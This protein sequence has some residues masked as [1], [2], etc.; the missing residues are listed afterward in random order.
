MTKRTG[1]TIMAA[2]P[3]LLGKTDPEGLVEMLGA[4]FTEVITVPRIRRVI[5]GPLRSPWSTD[6]PDWWLGVSLQWM[7]VHVYRGAP[8]WEGLQEADPVK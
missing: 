4:F 7:G 3:D 2:R 5:L 8:W 6:D 1:Y